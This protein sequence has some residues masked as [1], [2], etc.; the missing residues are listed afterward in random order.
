MK[1]G[2]KTGCYK[3]DTIREMKQ[4]TRE[5]LGEYWDLETCSFAYDV[6]VEAITRLLKSNNKVNISRLCSFEIVELPERKYYDIQT[7]TWK[8]KESHLDVKA[9]AMNTL[10]QDVIKE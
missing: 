9:K 1:K 10:K 7:K 2:T 6:F 5:I 8:I 3:D 4:I